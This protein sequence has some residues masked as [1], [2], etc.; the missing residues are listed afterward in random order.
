MTPEELKMLESNKHI[1]N[2]EIQTD[3]YDTQKE[4]YQLYKQIDERETFIRKLRYLLKLME[5]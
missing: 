2:S 1:L 3:I 5:E 4:I